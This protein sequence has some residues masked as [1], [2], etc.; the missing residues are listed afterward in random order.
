MNKDFFQKNIPHVYFLWNFYSFLVIALFA[1]FFQMP[2]KNF[3]APINSASLLGTLL[4]FSFLNQQLYWLLKMVFLAFMG[5]WVWFKHR[6][7]WGWCASLCFMLLGSIYIDSLIQAESHLHQVT[8]MFL[9]IFALKGSLSTTQ[10]PGWIFFL[11]KFY[12]ITTY[13]HA[14][15]TK[16][17]VSGV[18]WIEGSHMQA[19]IHYFGGSGLLRDM[20]LNSENLALIITICVLALELLCFIALLSDKWGLVIGY[21]LLVFHGLIYLVFDW[22]FYPLMIAIL[23][24]FILIPLHRNQRTRSQDESMA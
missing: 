24:N 23:I 10:F 9:L 7:I 21:L 18:D 12:L 19:I 16:L 8:A 4:D 13:M 5:A 6:A 20:V 1:V 14:S 15:L 17:Q 3:Q 11:M 22:L 2:V